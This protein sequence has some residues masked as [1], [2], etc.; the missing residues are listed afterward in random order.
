MTLS[1]GKLVLAVVLQSLVLMAM[2]AAR[3]YTLSTG[4][5]LKLLMEPIDP[6][7]LFRGDYVILTY[8][9]NQIDLYDIPGDG[10]FYH[11]MSVY[12]VLK[13]DTPYWSFVSVHRERPQ[14]PPDHII[15]KGRVERRYPAAD[16]VKYGIES[17]FVPEGEGRALERPE[18]GQEVSVLIA[19]DRWGN[20]AIKAV[21]VDGTPRYAE[22]L[23]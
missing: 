11:G 2:I 21:L 1:R 15:V 5:E 12:V 7:S 18:P 10:P 23:F 4:V 16:L 17:Y 3:Q 9:I 19:V 13:K 14:V 8:A 20:A 6:R 22:T